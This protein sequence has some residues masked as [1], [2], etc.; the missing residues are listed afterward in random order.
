L[1][2]SNE[3]CLEDFAEKPI[4]QVKPLNLALDLFHKVETVF[5]NQ[6]DEIQSQNEL[7]LT[8]LGR[9][10]CADSHLIIQTNRFLNQGCLLVVLRQA[11]LHLIRDLRRSR[12]KWAL[13]IV[14]IQR[15]P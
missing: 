9:R 3:F 2:S 4:L 5:Q 11:R 6:L 13:G 14:M 12:V 7:F 10:D 8:L 1:V 15:D